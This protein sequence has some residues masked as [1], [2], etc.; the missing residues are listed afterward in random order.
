MTYEYSPVLHVG[1]DMIVFLPLKHPAV[2]KQA[3]VFEIE[4]M[5]L[6]AIGS[7]GY[8]ELKPILDLPEIMKNDTRDYIVNRML[9]MQFDDTD[10][11]TSTG[12]GYMYE[13][14]AEAGYKVEELE[15]AM[16]EALPHWIEATVGE[17]L[18]N[19]GIDDTGMSEN[20]QYLAVLAHIEKDDTRCLVATYDDSGKDW[21]LYNT[22]NDREVIAL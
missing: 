1:E 2:I 7:A 19:F 3:H 15:K 5:A 14:Q 12:F 9:T 13:W 17:L 18:L 4:S 21:I 6:M 22:D 10:K 11:L 8:D 20:D 16:V